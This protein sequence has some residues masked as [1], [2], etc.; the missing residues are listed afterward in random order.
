MGAEAAAVITSQPGR[1]RYDHYETVPSAAGPCP[2]CGAATLAHVPHACAK[3]DFDHTAHAVRPRH[4]PLESASFPF[5]IHPG[6][7][8]R[9][10]ERVY[11]CTN[12]APNYVQSREAFYAMVEAGMLEE[13]PYANE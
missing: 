13:V 7:L 9:F 1:I 8:W 11:R 6:L 3:P 12:G 2:M 4:R 5:F 10:E